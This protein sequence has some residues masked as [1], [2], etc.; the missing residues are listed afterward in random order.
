[1]DLTMRRMGKTL[2][3]RPELTRLDANVAI[4]FKEKVGQVITEGEKRLV[5][6]LGRIEFVDSSGLG[7]LVALLKRLGNDGTL[8]LVGLRPPVQRLLALTRLDRVFRVADT[9]ESAE[10]ALAGERPV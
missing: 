8:A 10:R 1:M 5:L 6:D 2:V 7:A 3:L 9:V 4:T